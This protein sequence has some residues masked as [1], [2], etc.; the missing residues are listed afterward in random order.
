MGSQRPKTTP[1]AGP[2][3]RAA[4]LDRTTNEQQLAAHVDKLYHAVYCMLGNHQ[5]AED[6]IQDVY[7]KA[8]AHLDTFRG[9][10]ALSTW[11]Y[12]IAMNAARAHLRNRS[13]GLRLVTGLT[14][15]ELDMLARFATESDTLERRFEQM[16]MGQALHKAL[17]NLPPEFREVFVLHQF[18]NKSYKDIADI[19]NISMGTVESRMYR[20]REK[21]RKDLWPQR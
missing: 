7:L 13:R 8:Y 10:A 21:M 19:L 1:L 20:A 4:D 3:V 12:T 6:V 16:Q 15:E 9:E 18:E 5:D 17:L 2:R 11:L 14:G